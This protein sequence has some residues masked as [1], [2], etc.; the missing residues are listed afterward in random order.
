MSTRQNGNHVDV[1]VSMPVK[2]GTEGPPPEFDLGPGPFQRVL[3]VKFD[4]K[5]FTPKNGLIRFEI[6]KAA[7]P[8][9]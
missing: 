6:A 5:V 2:I 8:V 7:Q 1:N 3:E 4:M 9:T